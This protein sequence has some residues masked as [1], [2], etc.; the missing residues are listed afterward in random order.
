M[1]KIISFGEALIDMIGNRGKG[2]IETT[3][4]EKHFGGA[5]A[6]Y[7]IA[8]RRLGI[9]SALLTRISN[10]GFGN[11]LIK[12]LKKNKVDTSMIVRTD[13]KTTL[14]FVSLNKRGVPEFAFYRNNTADLDVRKKDIKEKYFDDVKIFHFCSLSLVEEPVRSSLFH[15]LK[16]AKKRKVLI[17][18]D[19]NLRKDLMKD[20]TMKYVRRAA[21][22]ADVLIPSEEELKQIANEKEID[23]A[24]L[25]FKNKRIVVTRGSKGSIMY[26]KNSKIIVPSFKVNVI[27]TTGAGDAFSAGISVG[28]I[29]GYEGKKLLKFASAVA[30]LSI[31]KKGAISSLPKL[32]DVKKFLSSRKF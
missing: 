12:T 30:A 3:T 14:A 8:V 19:P 9:K 21:K 18:Y 26:Y 1:T 22:Y 10:D 24:A 16:I 15:A 20:D 28:I 2:L 17:S 5:P 7:T 27:D 13:K 29:N 31:Q 32:N 25:H 11:F 6:N 4:F 23:E